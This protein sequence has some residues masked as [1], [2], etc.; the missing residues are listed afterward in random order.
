MGIA[1]AV[2]SVAVVVVEDR[3]TDDGA[4]EDVGGA[5]IHTTR[6]GGGEGSP[7]IGRLHR[8]MTVKRV[9]VGMLS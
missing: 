6:W 2:P 1:D 9:G 8:A 3:R 7:R 4:L 5:G